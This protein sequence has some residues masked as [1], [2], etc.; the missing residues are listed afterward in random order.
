MWWWGR[1]GAWVEMHYGSVGIGWRRDEDWANGNRI[2]DI[3][4]H[5]LTEFRKHWTC[6][7]NNNQ[8]LWQCR[9][10]ERKL[11]KCVF[12]NLV[13]YFS[14]DKVNRPQLIL[15]P[16]TR[17][18]HPKHTTGGGAGPSADETDLLSKL[19]GW[20]WYWSEATDACI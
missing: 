13:C 17:E 11:N 15:R 16:E 18:G 6:L 20:R 1:G 9:P 19:R 3:N 8:Q 14:S 10:A 7:D 2:D 4:K 5:C 12:E